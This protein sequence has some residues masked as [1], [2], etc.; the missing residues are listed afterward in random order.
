MYKIFLMFL[1]NL[2]VPYM[3]YLTWSLP[4]WADAKFVGQFIEPCLCIV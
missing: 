3:I 4:L 1:F 2:D